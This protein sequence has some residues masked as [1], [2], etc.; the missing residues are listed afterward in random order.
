MKKQRCKLNY[1]QLGANKLTPFVG[2]ILSSL[3]DNA[4]VFITPPI[5]K[6]EFTTI[7][8][9]FVNASKDYELMGFIK[10]NEFTIAKKELLT[11][12]D[13]LAEYVDTVA[14][15]VGSTISLA[16]FVPTKVEV[17][18]S[19]QLPK[20]ND[21]RCSRNETPGKI[22]LEFPVIKGNYGAIDYIG[23]CSV[24]NALPNDFI[25][26][27]TFITGKREQIIMISTGHNRKKIF[28]NLTPGSNCYVYTLL[29]NNLGFSELSDPKILIV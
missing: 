10:L 6:A 1:H 15:G 29:N 21:F 7:F 18:K 24:G 28:S 16:G 13:T 20:V 9:K 22:T 8:L 23:I 19:V 11:A 3:Y 4:T 26:D 2:G 14:L 17:T 12:T 5:S 27:N 25:V